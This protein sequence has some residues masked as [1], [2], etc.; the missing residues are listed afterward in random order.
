MNR[1]L[2]HLYI[3]AMVFLTAYS[4]V[5]MRWQV[6]HA[7]NLPVSLPGKIQFVTGLLLNP[8]VISGIIATFFAGVSWMLALTKFQISYAYPFTS[9]VYMLVL[10]SGV[11]FFRDGV[12]AGRLVGTA[13]VMAGV[14]IIA[15]FG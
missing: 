5:I 4:Q 11:V 7:G 1:A 9:L 8:W 15:R 14:L 10:A 12:N 13:V 2:D 3:I 6:G